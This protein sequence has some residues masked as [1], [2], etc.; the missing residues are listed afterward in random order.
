MIEEA[1]AMQ[2]EA[3]KK[4]R[5]A[6]LDKDRIIQ[7]ERQS[8]AQTKK[9]QLEKHR[10]Q[11][12]AFAQFALKGA[13]TN[14]ECTTNYEEIDEEVQTTD[15]ATVR[16]RE[17]EATVEQLE[18]K[19]NALQQRQPKVIQKTWIKNPNGKKGGAKAW[20]HHIVLLIMEWLSNRTPPSCI[21]ANIL[22]L[23]S[24]IM[25]SVNIAL[26]LPTTP[27]IRTVRSLLVVVTKTLAAYTVAK[28]PQYHQLFTDGT[29]RRQTELNNMLIGYV[30]DKGLRTTTLDNMILSP[31][32]TSV[33]TAQALI[34]S[35]ENARQLL[36]GWIDVTKELYPDDGTIRLDHA[37]AEG[38]S[39]ANNDFGR[40]HK[41]LVASR[42]K[43]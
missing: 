8:S 5:E 18:T 30:T 31:D 22:S 29:S 9:S 33:S 11:L 10:N 2:S 43:T 36:R 34:Q 32:K 4:V 21:S 26:E 27:Y 7:N 39:R 6:K 19:L 25:P 37:G 23:C 3:G 12:M 38:Q 28:L 24:N 13:T 16:E 42:K 20:P 15:N 14:K 40:G 17:L 35:M 41:R 1:K